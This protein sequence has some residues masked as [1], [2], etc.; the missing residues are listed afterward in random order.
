MLGHIILAAAL[1]LWFFLPFTVMLYKFPLSKVVWTRSRKIF[2]I[3]FWFIA[4]LPMLIVIFSMTALTLVLS[5]LSFIQ[6]F[7]LIHG[8][9]SR[10]TDNLI[11]ILQ[12]P[13]E[14]NGKS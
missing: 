11:D 5:Y 9:F 7:N 14:L 4:V 3:I 10:G 13:V 12:F 1:V 8:F 2:F 6:P